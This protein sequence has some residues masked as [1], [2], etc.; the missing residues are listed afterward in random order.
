MA[1]RKD[2]VGLDYA[3]TIGA[4]ASKIVSAF[5]SPAALAAWW[6]AAASIT[7]PR[8]MGPYAIEWPPT[9]ER[10]DMLGQLGGVLHGTIMEH[11]PEKGFFVA[12]V[13]WLPPEGEPIGPMALFVTCSRR[14]SQRS[15]VDSLR[16]RG[17]N[18]ATNRAT[19]EPLPPVPFTELHVVQTG[20][21]AESERWRRYYEIL[22]EGMP[23][24][25]DRLKQYL[26]HG[27]GA[28][29]LGAW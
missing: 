20:L 8:V 23:A 24:A 16:G 21:D 10:D 17:P 3:L 1:R 29:D 9:D 19:G 13:Y 7:T 12:D 15:L 4:P 6:D 28:W 2:H 18:A 14:E 22:G 5:F 25:L 11:H 26:E 27:R